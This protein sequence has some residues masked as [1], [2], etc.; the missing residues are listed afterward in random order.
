M[1]FLD[2]NNELIFIQNFIIY[3]NK[4][5]F[6]CFFRLIDKFRFELKECKSEF[7]PIFGTKFK[8]LWGRV[9]I[10]FFIVL[11]SMRIKNPKFHTLNIA[12]ATNL[13][14]FYIGYIFLLANLYSSEQ[15]GQRITLMKCPFYVFLVF[16]FLSCFWF[17]NIFI[18]YLYNFLL[19]PLFI[20]F[21]S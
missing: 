19:Y 2:D 1:F 11:L 6:V 17:G 9:S 14:T 5:D 4:I 3:I 8:T 18:F 15:P 12:H 21:F 20:N 7:C 13:N 10:L 16:N